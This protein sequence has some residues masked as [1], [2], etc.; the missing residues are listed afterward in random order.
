MNKRYMVLL[1]FMVCFMVIILTGCEK[2]DE[3][4]SEV[5]TE[6]KIIDQDAYHNIKLTSILNTIPY[7]ITTDLEM[8]DE[9]YGRYTLKVFDSKSAMIWSLVWRDINKK[10]GDYNPKRLI[11]DDKVF[12]GIQ[13]VVS[14]HD[15]LTGEFLWE[16]ETDSFVSGFSV[17]D[18]ILYILNYDGNLVST[19][20]V[21]TGAYISSWNDDY[22]QVT[23]IDVD[24]EYITLYY[25]TDDDYERNGYLINKDWTYD[26]RVKY[27]KV[28][29]VQQVWD[30][31][32]SSDDSQD[33][34]NIID[35]SLDSSWSE[36]VKG[37]GEK[38][39]VELKKNI[40]VIV[41]KLVIYN[42]DHTSEKA[43]E[44]CAKIKKAM[45]SVGDNKSFVYIFEEFNYNKPSIIEFI[46]PITADYMFIQIVEAEAGT[47]YKNTAITEV[48]TQ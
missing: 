3:E 11:V 13:G 30:S 24:G 4:I 43:F 41:N 22:D 27:T 18:N 6:V 5:E 34:V 16:V 7:T 15:L 25:A 29:E 23:G 38:E 31:A 9:N 46:R 44:E 2:K 1:I 40:P 35:G 37:Y 47:L 28:N 33:V 19:F 10:E 20:D 48:Y 42:G 8:D 32:T 21:S 14:V 17:Y 39:W 36:S 26:K 12:M 45:I